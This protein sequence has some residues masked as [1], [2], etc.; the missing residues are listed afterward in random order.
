MAAGTPRA[1]GQTG[2]G[3]LHH[4]CG[5]AGSGCAWRFDTFTQD[6]YRKLYGD[7]RTS[8]RKVDAYADLD[9]LPDTPM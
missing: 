9:T 6:D 1:R 8:V 7:L 2:E 5:R 3:R 4:R